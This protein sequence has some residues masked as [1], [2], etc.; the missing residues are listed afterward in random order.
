MVGNNKWRFLQEIAKPYS[1]DILEAL[2]SKPMRFTDL[3]KICK[4]QKTLTQCLHALEDC[5][6]V[7]KKIHREKK[8]KINVLYALTQKGKW[9]LKLCGTLRIYDLFDIWCV[10]EIDLT[11]L[12][13]PPFPT[14]SLSSLA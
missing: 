6:A 10:L 13:P 14:F 11:L 1:P 9:L 4:S 8:H 12:P 5:E 3:K 2:Q 7:A